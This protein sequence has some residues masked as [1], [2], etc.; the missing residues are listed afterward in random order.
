MDE[1]SP[2]SRPEEKRSAP[3]LLAYPAKRLCAK[4]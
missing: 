2:E 4:V 1:L 3:A